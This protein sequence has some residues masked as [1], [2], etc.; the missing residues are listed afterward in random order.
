MDVRRARGAEPGGVL[1]GVRRAAVEMRGSS[2]A[3]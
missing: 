2:A 3:G 1:D